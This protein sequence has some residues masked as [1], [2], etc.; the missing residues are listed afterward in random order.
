VIVHCLGEDRPL[1]QTT[2]LRYSPKSDV[3]S[4]YD[5]TG[6][7]RVL[8]IQGGDGTF[9]FDVEHFS[10]EPRERSW[11]PCGRYSYPFLT[12]RNARNVKPAIVWIG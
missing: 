3:E 10:D 4:I 7:W 5:A 8:I 1:R 12:A 11:F 6:K 9:G 2:G